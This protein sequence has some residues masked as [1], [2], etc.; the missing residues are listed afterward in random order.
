VLG[1]SHLADYSSTKGA[2]NAFTKALAQ[3]L[4]EKGIRVNAVAPGPVWTPLNAV[5]TGHPPEKVAEF[6]AKSPMGR[7]CRRTTPSRSRCW[8][9]PVMRSS[10]PRI[11]TS[12]SSGFTFGRSTSTT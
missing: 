7:L 4:V 5:D 11:S 9:R 8:N 3:D 6:G 10:S 12:T 1:S 2:I